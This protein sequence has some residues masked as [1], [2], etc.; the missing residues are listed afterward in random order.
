MAQPIST[1]SS[2]ELDLNKADTFNGD[3]EGFKK[4]LQDIE[5]YMDVNHETY[6]NNLRKITFVL[7]FMMTGSAAT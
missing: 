1:N 6:N 3:R 7:S 4:F 2:K 5:V